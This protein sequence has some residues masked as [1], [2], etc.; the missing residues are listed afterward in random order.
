MWLY[1]VIAAGVCGLAVVL[2]VR[3]SLL[4]VTVAGASME[5]TYRDGDRLLVSR[6]RRPVVGA[7]VVLRQ[8]ALAGAAAA[9]AVHRN[10]YL[11]KRLV[12]LPG[13]AVPDAVLPALD[14]PAGTEVP[15][16]LEAAAPAPR[17]AALVPAG[18]MVVL[19]DSP[20]SVDSRAWG[21]LPL[22]HVVGVVVADLRTADR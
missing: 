10:P 20:H 16:P 11:V 14:R 4:I 5:P 13:D 15:E 6:R 2:A 1:V 7:V 19:G 18:S 8:A 12:A 3:R 22:R 17:A 21:L 9:A